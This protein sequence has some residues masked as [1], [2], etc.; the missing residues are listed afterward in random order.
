MKQ[1]N[2]KQIKKLKIIFKKY[3]DETLNGFSEEELIK[4]EEVYLIESSNVLLIQAVSEEAKRF[5][6]NYLDKDEKREFNLNLDYYGKQEIGCPVTFE[7]FEL[8]VKIFKIFE[9]DRFKIFCYKDY[10][11]KLE[12]E[13]FNI[14][15]APRVEGD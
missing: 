2:E 6:R 5:F 10:P 3:F 9:Q 7:Y 4:Q 13:H 11:I 12:S 1:F 8:A 14:I 15:I